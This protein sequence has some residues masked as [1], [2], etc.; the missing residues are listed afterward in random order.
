[1]FLAEPTPTPYDLHFKVLGVPCRIH[2]LFW[3]VSTLMGFNEDPKLVLI[4]I[5]SVFVSILV[6][7]MGH[8]LLIRYF[9]WSPSVVLYSFGGLAIYNPNLQSFGDQRQRRRNRWTQIVISFAGPLAGFLLAGLII[10]FLIATSTAAGIGFGFGVPGDL[11]DNFYLQSLIGNLLFI[12]IF[13]GILNLL[14]I[15]PLDGGK[16]SREVFI[17]VDGG[18]GVRN[19]LMLS[20]VVAGGMALWC[21]V[22]GE[23]FLPI[24]FG[25]MAFS[26]YQEMNGPSN[27]YGGNPW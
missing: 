13:W 9:G 7:E 12:N 17:M 11:L 4:W 22:G 8:A 24:F 6:H 27:R 1:M 10:V 18:N 15:Y 19:S 25:F 16:I 5:A 2:P 23:R 21:L 14:P 20:M 3:L 26:N